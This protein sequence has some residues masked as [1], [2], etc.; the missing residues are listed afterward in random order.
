MKKALGGLGFW[1]ALPLAGLG[2]TFAMRSGTLA[3]CF[4]TLFLLLALS[5]RKGAFPP[6][7]TWGS[8]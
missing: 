3:I 4:Y 1:V 7:S 2:L 8:V 5:L 6:T